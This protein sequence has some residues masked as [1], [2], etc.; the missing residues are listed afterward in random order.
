MDLAVAATLHQHVGKAR[1]AA[2]A[3]RQNPPKIAEPG[4]TAPK[5]DPCIPCDYADHKDPAKCD[6]P[7][8]EKKGA[9]GCVATR[10]ANQKGQLSVNPKRCPEGEW[11]GSAHGASVLG[12]LFLALLSSTFAQ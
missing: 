8:G 6:C 3:S 10:C 1:L 9:I 7:P 4:A 12:A 2:L 11:C 5:P